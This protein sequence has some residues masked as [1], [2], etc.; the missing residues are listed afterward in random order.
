MIRGFFISVSSGLPK[1]SLSALLVW[2]VL[3]VFA[4]TGLGCIAGLTGTKTDNWKKIKTDL[5][6]E[7]VIELVGKPGLI[8]PHGAGNLIYYYP[9]SRASNCV[10]DRESCTPVVFNNGRV[11]GIGRMAV[12][13]VPK[14]AQKAK[15]R[16]PTPAPAPAPTP[17]PEPEKP[18]LDDDTRKEIAR[19]DR[20]VRQIPAE[21]TLDNMRVYKYLLKLDPE[22]SRYRQKVALYEEK[23][24]KEKGKREALRLYREEIRKLQNRDLKAFQGNEQIL[25][26]MKILGGGKFYV[27]LKNTGTDL[28]QIRP[29]HFVLLDE[30]GRSYDCYRCRDMVTDLIAGGQVEGRTSFDAI[31]GPRELVFNHPSAGKVVRKI[32]QY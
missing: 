5:T 13:P 6:E 26:A 21:H 11:V 9:T 31:T 12:Q 28:I 24:Q 3:I 30:A 23:F 29:D 25:L 22:N 10:K 17:A 15:P 16:T 2:G 7:E 18:R 19:L 14:E 4:A 1:P 20:F 27:W 32:P 8:A